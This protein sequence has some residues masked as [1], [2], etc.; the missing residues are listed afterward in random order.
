MGKLNKKSSALEQFDISVYEVCE[1]WGAQEWLDALIRRAP[2]Y[3]FYFNRL[4]EGNSKYEPPERFAFGNAEMYKKFSEQIL[5][6]PIGRPGETAQIS[7]GSVVN[8]FCGADALYAIDVSYQI[9]EKIGFVP[10]E[11]SFIDAGRMVGKKSSI[12]YLSVNFEHGDEVIKDSFSKWLDSARKDMS[13]SS[14]Y[15]D[16]VV[17]S[18]EFRR[19][20]EKRLLPFIDLLFASLAHGKKLSRMDLCEKLFESDD[21]DGNSPK[22]DMRWLTENYRKILSP[23]TLGGLARQ[24]KMLSL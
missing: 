11:L 5:Q 6:Y 8:D 1:S 10:L 24:V 13:V 9:K 16:E 23:E 18:D 14:K 4:K 3:R 21:S 15:A 2:T 19:W 20:H 7:V 17:G 22:G 12:A